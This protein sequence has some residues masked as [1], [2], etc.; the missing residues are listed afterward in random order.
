M[1]H[2]TSEHESRYVLKEAREECRASKNQE[3][4]R[5]DTYRQGS[6]AE[7]Q[8]PKAL[9]A[10]DGVG[11][12]W[13]YMANDEEDHALVAE[14][15]TE[16]ALMADTST[17]NKVFD[18]SLCLKDYKKN[19]D[20]LNSQITDLT[21]K[22]FDA[23]NMIYH[24]K[25]ALAQVESRLVEYKEREVKYIEKIRT[26]EFYDKGLLSISKDL[27]NLIESQRSD[28]SKEG[29]GYTIVPL[30]VAQLYLSHKKD[31]S[32]TGLPE[33]ADDTVT[34][35]SRP[36]PTVEISSE[37]DQ[38][39]NP[40]ASENFATLI[41]PKQFVKFVKASDSQSKSKTDEKETPEKPPELYKNLRIQLPPIEHSAHVKDIVA[42]EA[43]IA[44]IFLGN[45]FLLAVA[46]FFRQWEVPS[47]SGNFLTSSGNALCILFPTKVSTVRHKLLLFSLT[48]WC[49]SL[50]AFS[51]TKYALTINPHIYVSCIKQFWNTVVVKQSN[52]VTRLQALVDKKKVL[53]TEATIRDA[54]RLDDAKGVDC[55]PNEEIFAELA[56]MGYEKPSIKLTIYKA[57]FSSQWKFLI[58]TILQSLSA[59]RTYWNE[60]SSSMASAVICLSTGVETP[61]F[62]GM[63]VAEELEEQGDAEEQVQD[64]VDDAAQGAETAVSGDDVQDKS[65]PSPTP[66]PQQSQDLPSTS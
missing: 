7:E 49:C 9:M 61:L 19:N 21:D 29:L 57:F 27:D 5:R 13:S 23:K 47:G 63:L 42:F 24:Y 56:R 18:N 31:L 32:W 54:L 44:Q 14:A 45:T 52:D 58:H 37:E 65:I 33:C 12:D 40:S 50:S 28:K 17:E 26:L 10:I 30:H 36:A 39:R 20:S 60:F 53:I 1:E 3:R 15:P 41:T 48:N 34:D 8:T 62:E 43:A 55:L 6:K 66:P 38:N 16:F 25:L 51:Y 35:Y 64:D 4:G 46:F 2:G 11:W 59:K 22:L